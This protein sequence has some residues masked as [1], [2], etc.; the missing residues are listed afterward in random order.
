MTDQVILF[1]SP[2]DTS[3]A[4]IQQVSLKHTGR[5]GVA[6]GWSFAWLSLQCSREEMTELG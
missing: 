5:Q 1:G 2:S 4:P 6:Q 3:T